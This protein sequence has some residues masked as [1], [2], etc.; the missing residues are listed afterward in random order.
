MLRNFE[1]LT[2]T[3]CNYLK[4]RVPSS[5]FISPINLGYMPLIGV[6]I[7]QQSLKGLIETCL[8][9]KKVKRSD[10]PK[11]QDTQQSTVIQS[12][13][14]SSTNIPFFDG[15]GMATNHQLYSITVMTIIIEELLC[16]CFLEGGGLHAANNSMFYL[17]YQ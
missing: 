11:N 12:D 10:S 2:A 1:V 15:D 13:S 7:N 14:H 5:P 9:P 3:N 17:E 4:L 16:V 6:I 8:A